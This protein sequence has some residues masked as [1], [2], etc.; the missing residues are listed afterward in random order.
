FTNLVEPEDRFQL[1]ADVE[2]PLGAATLRLTGLYGRTDTVLTTSPSYL[3]TIAPSSNA[4]FGGTGLFVIPEYAPA[5]IDYCARYGADSG[6]AVGADGVPAAPALAYPVRFRPSLLGGSP[7]FDNDRQAATP[8]Y[9]GEQYQLTASVDMPI[10][11][12]MDL[13]GGLTWSRNDRRFQGIDNFVD[14][15]QNALAGF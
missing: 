7:L 14:L 10:A 6:C 4:A 8:D 3:P 1:F 2:A 9:E 15:L 13:Q 12:G 5:L 11:P